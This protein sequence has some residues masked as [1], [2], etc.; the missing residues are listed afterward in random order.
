MDMHFHIVTGILLQKALNNNPWLYV[1]AC[2]LSHVF[3]DNMKVWELYPANFFGWAIGGTL[4]RVPF[5]WTEN[6]LDA[7]LFILLGLFCIIFLLKARGYLIGGLVA[8]MGIDFLWPVYYIGNWWLG[9][10]M[11]V[12]HDLIVFTWIQTPWLIVASMFTIGLGLYI[13]NSKP[14]LRWESIEKAKSPIFN[15]L[16]EYLV[17]I[18]KHMTKQPERT[19]LHQAKR[20][21]TCTGNSI[22][23]S[24]AR[25]S[26]P[27]LQRVARSTKA[28]A[29]SPTK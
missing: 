25:S 21:L 20:K 15:K 19:I 12:L 14:G 3:I 28:F 2:L 29:A 16:E 4:E 7:S 26:S 8:W 23:S 9:Y 17:A 5:S 1:P 11:P 10:D 27:Q 18:M 22:T 6:W 24:Q 13:A